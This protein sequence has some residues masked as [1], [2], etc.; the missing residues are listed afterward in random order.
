MRV[1]FLAVFL[2]FSQPVFAQNDSEF[3]VSWDCVLP[4]ER[5]VCLQ[6]SGL[7]RFSLGRNGALS[8]P[9]A[10]EPTLAFGGRLLM[11]TRWEGLAIQADLALWYESVLQWGLLEAFTTWNWGEYTLS[12]GKRGAYS[13][14]WD[15]T[16]MGRD[17]RWGLFARY[18]P[19]D[20][21]WLDI[22]MAYLPNGRFSGGQGFVGA[23][24]GIFR[25]GTFVE[26]VQMP[27]GLGELEPS[28]SLN[29]RVGLLGREVGLFW[30]S[31]RGFWG[32][33]SLPLPLGQVLAF[34][35]QCPCDAD[36][37][38]WVEALEKSRLEGFFWW[39]PEWD[40]LG[41]NSPFPPEERFGAWLQEPR[42]LLIGAAYSWND[43]LRLGVDL[44]RA[45]I[46]ALRLYLQLHWR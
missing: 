6:P 17:G 32:S 25:M 19:V 15:D 46:E 30:Q 37:Q 20:L 7:L 2:A 29:P 27:N 33:A 16:L 18:T 12:L 21:P 40:F 28:F 9:A 42:K 8:Q 5:V 31:D 26:V 39:N 44:S 45:P 3:R 41:E 34:V 24:A 10:L 38:S 36:T 13:G 22:E 43:R 4:V 1:V 35:L 11:Q 14:P 23:N